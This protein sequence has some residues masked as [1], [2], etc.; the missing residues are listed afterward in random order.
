MDEFKRVT[1]KD[2]AQAAGVERTTVSL[3]LRNHP[4]IPKT[5]RERIKEIAG[6][7]GYT[8]DPML[9]A[10]I[11]YRN[12]QRRKSFQGTIA[13]L[14]NNQPGFDWIQISLFHEYFDGA[15][16][17]A[18]TLGYNIEVFN[19][20]D[21]GMTPAKLARIFRFR[22]INGI[23]LCPQPHPTAR[24]E[25]PWEYFSVVSFGYSLTW[26]RFHTAAPTQY[27]N[28]TESIANLYKIGYKRIGFACSLTT[29]Q[30]TDH[31]YLAGYF[32]E[33]F[34]KE[35]KIDI[36]PFDEE[37]ATPQK[38]KSWFNKYH[39]DAVVT[40]NPRLL[41]VIRK[42]GLSIPRDL[43]VA[44]PSLPDINSKL[45]GIYENSPDVGRAAVEFLIGKLQQ[46]ERG[47]PRQPHYIHVPGIWL[48]GETVR[49]SS[50]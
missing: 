16:E 35:G 48:R 30:R 39:P 9:S 20:I 3:A 7:L 26:P 29:D 33:K 13:W 49:G 10:L 6:K 32:A 43:G 36:P 38:F 42:A 37:L 12:C 45:S 24:L 11:N 40:N 14:V 34:L 8:P 5:T 21:K 15:A 18:K 4:S 41:Q 50:A 28:M 17:K 22:N 25:F 31:N 19:L 47:I 2:I 1:Q 44:C 46:E 27:R 23:L